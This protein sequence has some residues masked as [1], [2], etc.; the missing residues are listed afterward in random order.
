MLCRTPGK[1]KVPKRVLFAPAS[2]SVESSAKKKESSGSRIFGA[3]VRGV[4]PTRSGRQGARIQVESCNTDRAFEGTVRMVGRDG[5]VR[6]RSRGATLVPARSSF[7]GGVPEL[8][9]RACLVRS[10]DAAWSPVYGEPDPF[11]R[12]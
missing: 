11:G 8:V 9:L 10:G 4:R 12:Q 3:P 1:N 5:A 2:T 6:T 7:S